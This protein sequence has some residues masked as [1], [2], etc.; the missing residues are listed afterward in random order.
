MINDDSVGVISEPVDAL[1]LGAAVDVVVGGGVAAA[2][3][4]SAT[5]SA[6][7]ERWKTPMNAIRREDQSSSFVGR[8][9][10]PSAV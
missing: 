1:H 4:T 6:P 9:C 5:P 3:R 8:E 10:T 7:F 2:T